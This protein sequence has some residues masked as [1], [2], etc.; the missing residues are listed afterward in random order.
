MLLSWLVISQMVFAQIERTQNTIEI[1]YKNST[2]KDLRTTPKSLN[3]LIMG[4]WG[5]HGQM[6]QKKVAEQMS[7]A[8]EALNA[9]FNLIV[10]DNFYPNGVASVNDPSW[11]S[12][13]EDVYYQHPLFND[14]YVA[15]GNHDYR[16]NPDA[17]VAYS[18][19]SARWHMPSRYFSITKTLKDGTKADFFIIDTSPFQLDYYKD[20]LYADQVKL[21]DTLAQKKW[22]EEGLKNSKANWKFVV[23]HHPLFS[24]GKR[25]DKTS[26]MLY[27]F[28]GLF[29]KYKVDAYF[30]GHEHHLEYDVPSGF[31]FV[32]CISGSGGEATAVTQ[33]DFAKFAIQDFGFVA[34]SLTSKELLLQYINEEGKILYTTALKKKD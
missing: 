17:E 12:S 6:H 8:A 18:K 11:K 3:F 26:N 29:E 9:S 13:F 2:I 27:S 14:W 5:R 10:G 31:H 25:K 21:V 7:N 24:A 22:L 1:D 15:L 28:A 30:C 32:Q 19:I 4:D 34:A 23:G 20:D 33:A 16:T